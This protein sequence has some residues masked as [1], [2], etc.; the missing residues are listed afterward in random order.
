MNDG[1]VSDVVLNAAIVTLN[2]P[3]TEDEKTEQYQ[4]DLA[5]YH[6]F[7]IGDHHGQE[8]AYKHRNCRQV[9]P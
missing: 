8:V 2:T 3:P 1:S 5:D 4:K 7:Q 6:G 9:V